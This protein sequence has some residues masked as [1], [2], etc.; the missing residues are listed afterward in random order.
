MVQ[1]DNGM[2]RGLNHSWIKVPILS[3]T[4]FFVDLH[5]S[6]IPAVVDSIEAALA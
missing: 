2:M 5:P 4:W 6:T 1:V 3:M